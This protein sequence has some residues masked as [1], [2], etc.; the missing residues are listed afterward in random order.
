LTVTL[1]L[2][3]QVPPAGMVPALKVND[4]ALAAGAN[5]GVPQP[6]VLAPGVAATV[7]APGLVGKVS[8]K[9]T[10]VNAVLGLGLVMV[11]VNTL[12]APTAIC[13]GT[14]FLAMLG[15]TLACTTKAAVLLTAPVPALALL[16]APA[17]LL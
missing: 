3:V 8:A 16:T 1:T 4:T 13:E 10:P 5:V 9:A 14:K 12:V 6:L 2:T 17:V 15:A 7:I 11:K